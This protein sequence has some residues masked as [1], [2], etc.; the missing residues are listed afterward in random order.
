MS[1]NYRKIYEKAHGKIPRDVAGRP[2]H[3]HHING[4]REDN[5]LENLILVTIEEHY[6][7]HLEQHDYYAALRLAELLSLD[8]ETLSNL[9]KNNNKKRVENGTHNFLH[10][11][12]EERSYRSKKTSSKRINDGTHHFLAEDFQRNVQLN[13]VMRGIHPFQMETAPSKKRSI[14]GTHHF[15]GGNIQRESAKKRVDDGTHHLLGG[16]ITRKQLVDGT[17]TS[18]KIC[19]C[20]YCNRNIKSSANYSRWHGERCKM[21]KD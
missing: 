7:I 13:L 6:Q 9:A 4:D 17:H 3:I 10:Q 18:Q 15:F 16:E 20:E 8:A 14:D 12:F 5:R 21:R 1:N 2:M 11:S 19:F